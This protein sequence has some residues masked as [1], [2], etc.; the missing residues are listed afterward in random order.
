ML[1]AQLKRSPGNGK[2]TETGMK[3]LDDISERLI[4][5]YKSSA[6]SR[7][8]SRR[9][10][11]IYNYAA[12]NNVDMGNVTQAVAVVMKDVIRESNL[13]YEEDDM[14]PLRKDLRKYLKSTP[15]RLSE[16]AKAQIAKDYG[17]YEKFRRKNFGSMRLT[18]DM[19]AP[20]LDYLWS[21][22]V[23]KYAGLF[24]A[25]DLEVDSVHM[26]IVFADVLKQDN[27]VYFS[28]IGESDIQT[29]ALNMATDAVQEYA[30]QALTST[31]EAINKSLLRETYA[32]KNTIKGLNEEMQTTPSKI[33]EKGKNVIAQ[34]ANDVIDEHAQ[35]GEL[36]ENSAKAKKLLR[37]ELTKLYS[38]YNNN[39][40][41]DEVQKLMRRIIVKSTAT[42]N[43]NEGQ[44]GEY[45]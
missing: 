15:I 22:I 8:I 18:S 27:T 3:A 32:Q 42:V 29:L 35:R 43:A 30:V 2:V 6:D 38:E 16:E 10:A 21:S 4:K 5:K 40:P 34:I 13:V 17:S 24:S 33:T 19:D 36:F 44:G 31:D 12:D 11:E 37:K 39:P 41:I 25:E 14:M 23:D 20:T 1:N 7:E 45:V 28:D 9:I 26:P